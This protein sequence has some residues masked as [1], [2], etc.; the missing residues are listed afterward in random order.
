MSDLPM[1]PC[2][3]CGATTGRYMGQWPCDLG[4]ANNIVD[5]WF[6]SNDH[7][8]VTPEVQYMYGKGPKRK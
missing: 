8:V 6:C 7:V 3:A 4:R 1:P 5:K 2:P